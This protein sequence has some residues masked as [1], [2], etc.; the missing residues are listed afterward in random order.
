MSRMLNRTS[1]ARARRMSV[2]EWAIGRAAATVE[3]IAAETEA[4]AGVPAAGGGG[5]GG[6]GGGPG[7]GGGVPGA[8]GGAG[9]GEAGVPEAVGAEGG[10]GVLGAAAEAEDGTKLC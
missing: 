7:A 9:A 10:T 2:P 1:I 6:G 5:G 4:V 8:V 3:E